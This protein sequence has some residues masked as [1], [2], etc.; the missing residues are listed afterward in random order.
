M[1]QDSQ[2]SCSW[3]PLNNLIV[4]PGKL[5]IASATRNP[6]KIKNF[7]IPAFAGMTVGLAHLFLRTSI[8]KDAGVKATLE[9]IEVHLRSHRLSGGIASDG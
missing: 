1:N 7:W 3:N 2:V 9:N 8:P 6:G 5:A 4:I